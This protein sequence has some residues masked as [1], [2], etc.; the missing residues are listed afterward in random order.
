MLEEQIVLELVLDDLEGSGTS[1]VYNDVP[2]IPKMPME[3]HASTGSQG[4]R[5]R[6][7]KFGSMYG[8]QTR[9]TP[10]TNVRATNPEGVRAGPERKAG[11]AIKPAGAK[12]FSPLG[13]SASP[14]LSSAPTPPGMG[15]GVPNLVA[16]QPQRGSLSNSLAG[17]ITQPG[18]KGNILGDILRSSNHGVKTT[19]ALRGRR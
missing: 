1:P 9:S 16:I 5:A 18:G 7:A 2:E 10:T 8:S 11:G 17:Q 13:S 15:R 3:N 19:H 12:S 4:T 14:R 6:Q